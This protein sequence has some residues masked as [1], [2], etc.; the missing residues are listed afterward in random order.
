MFAV[1]G[2]NAVTDTDLVL[3]VARRIYA[4]NF[5]A[6]VCVTKL[7]HTPVIPRRDREVQIWNSTCVKFESYVPQALDAF[8]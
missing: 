1:N 4:N 3:E 2:Y 7:Q 6:K 8:R 5:C